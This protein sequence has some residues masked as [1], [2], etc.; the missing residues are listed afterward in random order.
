VDCQRSAPNFW[1]VVRAWNGGNSTAIEAG[2]LSTWEEI[3]DRQVANGVPDVAVLVDSGYGAEGEAY[4]YANCARFCRVV[5]REDGLPIAMGWMPAK[6]M[7]AGKRWRDK[8]TGLEQSFYLRPLDPYQGTS[9]AGQVE[10]ELFEFSGDYFKDVLDNLRKSRGGYTWSVA[11]DVASDDYWR[12]MDAE[13]KAGEFNRRT[14]RTT[15][16]WQQRSKHWPNHLFDCEVLQ[17]AGANFFGIFNPEL[18]KGKA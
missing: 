17:V 1:H 10:M 18:A 6:G 15:F 7:P 3:R 16:R 13:V 4:V 8:L 5:N 11:A 2:P 14:G 12:H 9:Q